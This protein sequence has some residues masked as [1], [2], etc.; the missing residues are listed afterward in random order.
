MPCRYPDIKYFA[1][2]TSQVLPICEGG[3]RLIAH[4]RPRRSFGPPAKRTT[5]LPCLDC[6][7]LLQFFLFPPSLF[8]LFPALLCHNADFRLSSASISAGTCS[9]PA[10]QAARIF[11]FPALLRLAVTGGLPPL[12][13]TVRRQEA[14][15]DHDPGWLHQHPP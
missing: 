5:Y 9:A 8:L 3:L 1:S 10:Y 15:H 11:G 2:C 14:S 6:V 12:L 13:P 7:V 4:H